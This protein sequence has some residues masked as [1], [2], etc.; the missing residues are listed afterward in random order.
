LAIRLAL[1]RKRGEVSNKE[2]EIERYH[3]IKFSDDPAKKEE[4]ARLRRLYW[5]R[6]NHR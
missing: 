3:R 1:A 6:L 2:N 4:S 5:P